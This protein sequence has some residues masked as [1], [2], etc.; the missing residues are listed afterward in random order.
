MKKLLTLVFGIVL[1]AGCSTQ[2]Y[3]LNDGPAA[4]PQEVKRQA[5]F[6]YGVGQTQ[7]LNASKV[8]GGAQNV[9]K[10]ESTVTG[11]DALFKWITFNIY[12]PRTAKVYCAVQ[13]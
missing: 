9:V 11:I 4:Q 6:V 5:F 10:V 3:V 8:C 7:E 13:S 12:T 2:S 1:L